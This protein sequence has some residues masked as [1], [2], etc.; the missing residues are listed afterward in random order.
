MIQLLLPILMLCCSL[1]EA[2]PYKWLDAD[3]R[4]HY[5]DTPPPTSAQMLP[6]EQRH[7]LTSSRNQRGETLEERELARKRARLQQE[8]VTQ[9]ARVAEE[10]A[11]IK[12]DNCT[13]ARTVLAQLERGGR[14]VSTDENGERIYLD[15][16]MVE[17]RRR[18]AEQMIR[19]NC[20]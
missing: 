15:E 11:A 9:E 12:R 8:A 17:Q 20:E 13:K 18:E 14:L 5:S 7:S 19:D 1:A 16:E 3:G 4:L 6:L 2:A 10:N